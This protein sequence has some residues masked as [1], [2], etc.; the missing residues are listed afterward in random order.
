MLVGDFIHNDEFFFNADYAIYE[1]DENTV[2][3]EVEK[4]IYST[5][6]NGCSRPP[7]TILDLKVTYMTI[8]DDT[9]IIEVE[10][11]F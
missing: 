5:A 6:K 8:H 11:R 4:P 9:L 1:C 3:N 7:A 10:E 2:W